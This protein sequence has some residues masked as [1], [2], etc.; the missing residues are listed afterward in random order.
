MSYAI[1]RNAKY[2]MAN[3][4]SISRHNERRNQEYGNKDIDTSRSADNYH[5]RAPVERSYEREFE[6]VRELNDL[7]GN[8]RLTGKK[9]SNVACE[10][11]IT[12][13][14]AF[15]QD[16]GDGE[17]RRFFQT[18]Y[19]YASQKVGEKNILSAVVHMD[20]T[21]PHMHLTYIPVV[22]GIKK[23]QEIDKINCSE[24][25]KGFNSYG[26]LQDEFHAYI[27][28]KGFDLERGV[29]NESREE[30][31]E[32]LVME[33]YKLVTTHRDAVEAGRTLEKAREDINHA[34][35]RK[36]G[37]EGEIDALQAKRTILTAAEVKA[38]KGAKTVFGGLKDIDY[39][40]FEALKRTAAR[41]DRVEAERDKAVARAETAEEEVVA[42]KADTRRQIEEIREKADR[43]RPSVILRIE[44]NEL[45]TRFER[46]VGWLLRLLEV[47]PE[48]FRFY[49]Q[50]I[51]DDRD[52]FGRG[53]DVTRDRDRGQ[54]R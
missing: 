8:L 21:T 15:F 45:K 6:R 38:M 53:R 47:L 19:E 44:H 23:G 24:F 16:I 12:S 29:R 49:I 7:K 13:D 31:R 37:L 42:I 35:G 2:K 17:S 9:Q 36:K 50:N 10:F 4:R 40:Q 11:L 33:E 43:D 52:P 26:V 54:E 48:R 34:E 28:S 32:H 39:K 20:E 5:L 3:L 22:K 27:T 18:A 46:M 25:W 41:V 14:P 51:L 30:K 1:I